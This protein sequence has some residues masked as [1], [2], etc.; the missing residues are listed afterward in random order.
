[1]FLRVQRGEKRHRQIESSRLLRMRH[2][3]Q[4]TETNRLI[5][6]PDNHRGGAVPLFLS[7]FGFCEPAPRDGDTRRF[8][9]TLTRLVLSALNSGVREKHP[10]WEALLESALLEECGAPANLLELVRRRNAA[11]GFNRSLFSRSLS[12]SLVCSLAGR[13]GREL[14][15]APSA[16]RAASSTGVQ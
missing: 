3:P 4:T 15:S 10:D 9:L 16:P 5:S 8:P 13:P 11:A 14:F 2:L 1:M 6:S 12:R 7:R